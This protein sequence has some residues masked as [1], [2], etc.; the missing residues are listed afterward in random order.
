[1]SILIDREKCI[2]CLKCKNVCPGN[3]IKA[4]PDG[5]AF[6]KRPYDCWGCTACLKECPKDAICLILGPDLDG[7]GETLKVRKDGTGFLWE[8]DGPKGL[9]AKLFTDSKKSNEY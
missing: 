8:V 2:G 9:I 6:L 1:M 3:L 7:R 4:D 5:K